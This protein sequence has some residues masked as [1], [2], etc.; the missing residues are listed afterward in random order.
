LSAA[1]PSQSVSGRGI[2]TENLVK[3]PENQFRAIID[4]I[5]ALAW[6]AHLDGS[7][8]FFNQCWLDY[9]GLSFEQV[10]G[11]GWT[12]A[13]HSDD[14]TRIVDYWAIRSGFWRAGRNRRTPTPFRWCVSLVSF[15][16]DSVVRQRWKACQVVR[17]EH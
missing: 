11:W 10:R 7:A 16:R 8:E 4:T 6:S 17:Y 14:L 1:D 2:S 3:M 15:P 13:L 12:V 5:P 9:T